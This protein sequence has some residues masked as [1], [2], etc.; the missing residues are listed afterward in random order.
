VAEVFIRHNKL[1]TKAEHM[2]TIV[3][4]HVTMYNALATYG[5]MQ[6]D[7]GDVTI[8]NSIIDLTYSGKAALSLATSGTVSNTIFYETSPGAAFTATDT[9]LRDPQFVNPS[10]SDLKF[11]KTSPAIGAGTG[12]TNIGDPRW[13]VQGDEYAFTM[14]NP[15]KE[16]VI[17]DPSYKI[18]WSSNDPFGA[19]TVS[20]EYATSAEGPW[21]LIVDSVAAADASYTWDLTTL[22]YGTYYVR[23]T[24]NCEFPLEDI[25]K[26]TVQYK[27]LVPVVYY[28]AP[29]G[30]N[31]NDGLTWATAKATINGG[32]AVASISDTVKVAAGTYNEYVS[33][34]DGVHIYGSYTEGTDVQDL[35]ATPTILD[36]TDLGHFLLVKYDNACTRPTTMNG[37]I[38]QNAEHSADGGGAFL[39]ANCTLENCI[40]RNCTTAGGGGGVYNEGGTIRNCTIELCFA[41]GS[42]G[43]VYNKG[44]LLEN[45]IIRGNQGKYAAVR[46]Q[47]G[48]ITR[49]CVFYNNEPS[50]SGWPT[51]GGVYN[52]SGVVYNCTFACNYGDEYAGS[53]S[54]AVAYNNVF[55]NN[56]K[57][58]GFADPGTYVA[59]NTLSTNNAGDDYFQPSSFSLDLNAEN[60]HAE[61]PNFKAPTMFAGAPKNEGQIAAMRAADFSLLATS[62][63]INKGRSEGAPETDIN[64]V[65]RPKGAGVDIG[66]YEYDP[67]AP[68]IAVTG[69]K[70]NVDTLFVEEE[71]VNAFAAVFTPKNATNRNCTWW[72]ED[73]TI[74]TIDE[75]GAVTGVKVGK[76]RAAVKTE[77]GGFT[78][79]AIVV[80]TE[81]PIIIIHPEVLKFDTLYPMVN[82]TVPSF[83]PFWAAKEAARRDSSEANLQAMRDMVPTL[84]SK[85]NPY[86]LI[87]NINGD[88][89]TR[90]AFNWFTNDGITD[91]KVQLVAKADATV[92]DF[93]GAGVI[94]INATAKQTKQLRY[95][96][97]SSGI[98][99][100]TGMDKKTSYYYTSHKAL[101]D[102]LT[103]GTT[104]SYR[105]GYDT[106]WSEIATF[107]TAKADQ[108]EYSFLVMSDSHIMNAEYVENAR[109]CA[110]AAMTNVPEAK[111]VLFPGDAEET[112]TKSNSEWEWE[113][114]FETSMR[115]ALYKMPF[116]V[117]D[118]NH[119][120][121]ENLNWDVHYNTD[122]TFNT[123]SIIKPQF[124]GISYSFA[125]GD[126]LFI[127]FSMQDFWRGNYDY[128]LETSE[129][130]SRDVAKWMKAEVAK[131]PE[132][133]Y[134]VSVCHYNVF[135][136]SSHQ[137]DDEF[138]PMIRSCMLPVF[139]ECEIDLALQGHDHCYEV[140]GPVNPDT[141]T[142]ITS[143]I[144][145][146]KTVA[147]N[148]NT[149]MTGKEGGTFTVDDGTLYFI[150]ATCGRKRYYPFSREEMDANYSVHKVTN[151]FDLFTSKFGQPGSPVYTKITVKSDGLYLDSYQVN[152][153]DGTVSLYNSIKVVRTKAHTI[154]AGINEV[155]T[156]D[157]AQS[158]KF[159]LNGQFYIIREGKTYNAQGMRL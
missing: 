116:A 65:A 143:A 24:L 113:Q 47:D 79:T 7:G 5:I 20:L 72:I 155:Q 111:F 95:A 70:L 84:V 153:T 93:D 117:T 133:K 2:P 86:C 104:Y 35:D 98:I 1:D 13:G 52:P 106:Y 144:A 75:Y 21:T 136:G 97:S 112:G 44:G 28:V 9:L 12:G 63:L 131:Y 119:E 102:Q 109:A 49:N 33:I 124:Q 25:A 51:S 126:V 81:K 22:G 115:P 149:N 61:G 58:D 36:G 94:T 39:R 122:N 46:N 18:T 67:D 140:M 92:A 110:E 128:E 11:K 96:V 121:T 103:P 68:V 83:I 30:D 15:A 141:R 10:A 54:D 108:G 76:T 26:G 105:V 42:G 107:A 159:I 120:D 123:I 37:L 157:A 100:A 77:D 88:P 87:A 55:W 80:V 150:G 19:A 45:I 85:E 90:M 32:V 99:K 31:N 89:K 43:A 64:G 156:V 6:T 40:I 118:G 147:I 34:H 4:D 154:P 148:T 62:P 127:V 71:S 14:G 142:A 129:Y 41:E 16:E 69:V 27:E 60:M 57:E 29:T 132:C 151:Y 145:D 48:G 158:G 91:G 53:H 101:A 114:W 130:L 152:I 8:T 146:V 3:F 66:A 17:Y 125:Y 23:G 56:V 59:T 135:S 139:K 73:E 74:A 82:Y 134:R 138:G 38:L 78:D 50:T 137:K